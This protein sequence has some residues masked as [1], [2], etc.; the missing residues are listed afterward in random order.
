ML[1]IAI[2]DDEPLA[3][4]RLR[5]LLIPEE[6]V[7]V[8]GEADSAAGALALVRSARPD[9]VLLDIGM[10]DGDGLDVARALAGEADGPEVVFVTAFDAHAVEAF[11]LD[12]TD[13]LLKPVSADRL[14]TALARARARRG[15]PPSH[16]PPADPGEGSHILI[17]L[18]DGM[19]RLSLAQ[20]TWIEAARDYVLIHADQRAHILRATLSSLEARFAGQGLLRVSRSALVRRSAVARFEDHDRAGRVLVL[21]DGALV[22]V[23]AAYAGLVRDALAG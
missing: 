13:Y 8:V 6:G 1:R 14:A 20:V 3:R 12:A 2:V 4:E 19:L 21:R 18:R 22:R 15:R 7:A 23:G 16:R 9:I 10:P 5:T 11:A 17:P